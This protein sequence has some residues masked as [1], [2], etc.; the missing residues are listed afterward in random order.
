MKKYCLLLIAFFSLFISGCSKFDESSYDAIINQVLKSNIKLDNT[1]LKGYD[2][3]L[4]KDISLYEKNDTN[5]VLNFYGNKV[6]L[7]VDLISYYHKTLNKFNE[8]SGSFY[9]K[10]I[11]YNDKF[12]Y[13]E[14]REVKNGYFVELMYNYAKLEAYL[15]KGQLNDFIYDGMVILSSI[16]YKDSVINSLIGDNSLNYSVE[17]YNIFEPKQDVSDYLDYIDTYEDYTGDIVDEDRIELN[18]DNE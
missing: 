8:N 13:L 7:Y 12:G 15:Q 5:S 18:D 1:I 6:Y 4:P 10:S 11:N 17:V 3:Y 14:I 9:S 16:D 2:Y